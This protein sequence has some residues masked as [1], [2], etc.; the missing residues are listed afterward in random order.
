M[1]LTSLLLCSCI[2]A[3]APILSQPLPEPFIPVALEYS[4]NPRASVDILGGELQS[5]RG[6]GFNAVTFVVRWREAA[7]QRGQLALTTLERTLEAAARAGLRA[8]VRLENDPPAWL[9]DVFPDGRRVTADADASAPPAACFDHPGV[10][11]EL[12]SFIDGVSRT[13]ARYPAFHAIDVGGHPPTSFCLCPNTGRRF[14]ASSK[15]GAVDR[16]EFVRVALRDDLQWMVA[17]AAPSR[18]RAVLSRGA[19]P[20]VLP[21]P[22]SLGSGQDDW[23]MSAVV[24]HYGT[25]LSS[26]MLRP[27]VLPLVLDGLEGAARGKGWMAGVD[28]TVGGA[29][30][31]FAAWAALSRGARGLSFASVPEDAAFAGLVTR[32]PGLFAGL[33]P[34]RAQ[35]ALVFDPSGSTDRLAAIHAILARHNLP[36]DIVHAGDL[37]EQRVKGYRALV[38]TSPLPASRSKSSSVGGIAIVDAS[39]QTLTGDRL[40]QRL[41]SLD[42][43]PEVRIEGGKGLVETR[44]LESPRELMLIAMNHSSSSE[45]VT[46]TFAP[47]TQEAI[48]QNMEAGTGVNFIAGA[49]GPTYTYWFRPRD[50]LVLLIRKDLR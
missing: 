35:V 43:T 5:I 29:D 11:V 47:D 21:R 6:L 37:A 18:A 2:L 42:I 10:R 33:A 31:R 16:T 49:S 46:M 45:R 38:T 9:F 26:A 12:Q 1:R 36:V 41:A 15:A 3:L 40:I 27:S 39:Q 17:R 7:P 24:D 14:A 22:P 8:V 4:A 13:V 28:A 50:A 34:R 25:S 20:S 23:L 30:G 19:L 32:N 48:W 44:F